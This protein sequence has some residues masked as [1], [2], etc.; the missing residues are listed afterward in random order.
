MGNC[1]TYSQGFTTMALQLFLCHTIF[2]SGCN[3][4]LGLESGEISDG[5]IT[6]SSSYD[7]KLLAPFARLNLKR[8]SI[9]KGAWIAGSNNVNQWL[10]VD[11]SLQ[12]NVTRVATQGRRA[13]Y[14]D[15][16]LLG[17]I[18]CTVT[19]VSTFSTMRMKKEKR[20]VS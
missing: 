14:S 10:Q 13:G 4:A 2:L 3:K 11:L 12:Y 15:N 5:Q 1:K 20:K 18:C 7:S 16:G 19:M 8:A 9:T 6:A 17:T